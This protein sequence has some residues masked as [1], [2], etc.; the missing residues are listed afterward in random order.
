MVQ[1]KSI[2]SLMKWITN[3]T[4]VVVAVVTTPISYKKGKL[5]NLKGNTQFFSYF[6]CSNYVCVC[7]LARSRLC[8][9]VFLKHSFSFPFFKTATAWRFEPV[10]LSCRLHI[11]HSFGAN[12]RLSSTFFLLCSVLFCRLILFLGSFCLACYYF[13]NKTTEK[14]ININIVYKNV[15]LCSKLH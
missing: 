1:K 3:K 5:W 4:I 9:I 11:I 14:W 6:F 15:L 7:T 13:T 10:S 12:V 2:S 8:F